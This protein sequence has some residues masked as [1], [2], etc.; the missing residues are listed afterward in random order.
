MMGHKETNMT[1]SPTT[2]TALALACFVGAASAATAQDVRREKAAHSHHL[3]KRAP[4]Q[5]TR[6]AP[7]YPSDSRPWSESTS[8]S[9]GGGGGY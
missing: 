5:A 1:I 8:G 2:M 6:A 9:G 3:K 4:H 7:R